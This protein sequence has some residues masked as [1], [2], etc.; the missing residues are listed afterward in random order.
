MDRPRN[1]GW[2]T[3]SRDVKRYDYH[4]TKISPTDLSELEELL[5]KALRIAGILSVAI[6]L[7]AFLGWQYLTAREVV[8]AQSD[9]SIDLLALRELATSSDGAL[10]LRVN[11][12]VIAVASLPRAA[13]FA[14]ESFASH[15]MVHGAYQIVYPEGFVIIDAGLGQAT[16][17]SQMAGDEGHY[18][19][20]GFR[21]VL[22]SLP[23]ARSVILTHEHSDHIQ[24]LSHVE[25]QSALT[26]NVIINARQHAN[27][28]TEDLLPAKLLES[29]VPIDADQVTLVAP[30]VVLLPA[31]GH[32]PGSQIIYVHLQDGS[33]YLFLGDV[34]WHMDAL[35][36]LHYRPRLITDFFLDEDRAAVMAQIRTL[37]DLLNHP[38]LQLV[39]S[40]DI[41]QRKALVAS[42]KLGDGFTTIA[43]PGS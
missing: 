9:Y 4:L 12:Q 42:K 11:H 41:E 7:F 29:L 40:H 31:A 1:L 25:D 30:G 14:A 23:M 6:L 34:V 38:G 26:K 16:F 20:D 21:R 15:P 8:P 13:I 35:R 37:H 28:E 27:P 2:D 36:K 39:V 33:D 19:S 43:S 22:A 5:V 18:D 3:A 32:T 10:P 17:D 24:G